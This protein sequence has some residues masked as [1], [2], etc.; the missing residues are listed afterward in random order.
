[1][2]VLS[3]SLSTATRL[4]TKRASSTPFSGY[5]IS[6]PYSDSFSL[7]TNETEGLERW[8]ASPPSHT[9]YDSLNVEHLSDL[10][11][12]LPTRDGT[13]RSYVA[14]ES[15]DVLPFGHHLAFF[16]ARRAEAQLRADGTD[17]DISPPAPFTK[18]MWA[19]GKITWNNDNPLLVGHRTKGISTV[20]GAERKG[21]DKGKPMVFVTQK[22]EYVQEGQKIPSVVE[23]RAHVYFHADM[24]A[25]RK[26]VFDREV[27]G[28]PTSPDFSFKYTPTPVTLFRYSALMFNA[29]HIH[30]DKEYCEKEEGYPER[31]V[32]GPLTAQ[33]LLET[34]DFNVPGV[35]VKSF[36]YRATNPLF[37][38]RELNINGKWID[39]SNIQVWCSDVNGIVGMTGKVVIQ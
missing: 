24:F 35:Q 21:F 13:R 17:E 12:T 11:I 5:G 31:I 23:E 32:H 33:M 19:G 30:L 1:M 2:H 26:K 38:N 14:P 18:R 3:R 15:G 25:N 9:L 37:V 27:N 39:K 20:A 36:E 16:H 7:G 22:I 10:Y 4:S 28:I 6:R 8:I 34:V 29:H